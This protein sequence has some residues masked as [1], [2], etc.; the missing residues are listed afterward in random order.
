V[1][2][3]QKKVRKEPLRKKSLKFQYQTKRKER[4]LKSRNDKKG[5]LKSS[6]R[7]KSLQKAKEEMESQKHR[8]EEATKGSTKT[9]K[10][11]KLKIQKKNKYDDKNPKKNNAKKKRRRSLIL[12]KEMISYL[13]YNRV[14]FLY[15]YYLSC[16]KPSMP[17]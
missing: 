5:L 6:K 10:I 11:N 14:C 2:N 3:F 4:K 17:Q 7:K 8:N 15:I 9:I 16:I 12:Y 1:C 13:P